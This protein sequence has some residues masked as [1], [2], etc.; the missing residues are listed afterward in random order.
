MERSKSLNS[1]DGFLDSEV[2]W[3]EC[4]HFLSKCHAVL[5]LHRLCH[6]RCHWSAK[7]GPSSPVL[8]MTKRKIVSSV[9]H[10]IPRS[11]ESACVD[12]VIILAWRQ[13]DAPTIMCVEQQAGSNDV[14]AGNWSRSPS[15]AQVMS[16]TIATDV[17]NS[18][19]LDHSFE[20]KVT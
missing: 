2:L 4:Y 9:E 3:R 6:L 7:P 19:D 14:W 16:V 8:W 5:Q 17:T 18:L 11:D 13:V 20:K 10:S 12:P 1:A 15:L